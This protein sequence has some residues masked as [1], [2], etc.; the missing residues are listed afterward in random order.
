MM[1]LGQSLLKVRKNSYRYFYNCCIK[2]DSGTY[3]TMI[4]DCFSTPNDNYIDNYSQ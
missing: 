1:V 2:N 4:L 3:F